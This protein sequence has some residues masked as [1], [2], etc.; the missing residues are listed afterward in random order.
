MY[1]VV[2]MAQFQYK[3]LMSWRICNKQLK[4]NP[5]VRLFI[6][7]K[8]WGAEAPLAPPPPPTHPPTP[9]LHP[10]STLVSRINIICCSITLEYILGCILMQVAFT[11]IVSVP[12]T[13]RIWHNIQ[14]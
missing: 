8:K 6:V 11:N 12:T 1:F 3:I 10:Y 5:Q 9:Y 13:W 4:L 2:K 14:P 7:S